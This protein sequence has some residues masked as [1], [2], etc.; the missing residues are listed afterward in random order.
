MEPAWQCHS[1]ESVKQAV[2]NGHGIALMPM[3]IIENEVIEKVSKLLMSITSVLNA[4]FQFV[5]IKIKV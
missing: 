3:K 1:W 5:I 4:I 2:L